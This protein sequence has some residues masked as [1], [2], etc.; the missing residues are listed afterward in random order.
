MH[1]LSP[2]FLF[3]FSIVASAV[4]MP[5][6]AQTRDPPDDARILA[7]V[8]SKFSASTSLSRQKSHINI[9]A[10]NGVVRL[11]GWTDNKGDFDD[12]FD[13]AFKTKCVKM[14]NVNL[15]R[16]TPPPADDPLRSS[17]GCASGTKACGD[18]C[19]PSGDSCTIAVDVPKAE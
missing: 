12:L 18:V 8:V 16:P 11:Q 17:G 5:A 2:L 7:D 13:L 15:F 4:L 9:F 6:M 10:L 19:I 14:V 3:V 1:R